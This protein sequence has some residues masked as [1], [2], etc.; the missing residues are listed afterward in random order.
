MSG[1]PILKNTKVLI[2]G[3]AGFIGSNLIETLLSQNNQIVCLDNFFTGKKENIIPFVNLPSFHFI[4]GDIRNINC[5]KQAVKGVTYVFHQA[6]IGS[7]PRSIKDPITTNSVNADGFLNMLIASRDEKVKR[8]I[9]ASSSSVYGDHPALPKKEESVGKP[10]SPYGITKSINEMYASVFAKLYNMEIIGLR[11]FNVFGKRQ[12]P[13]GE[14]AAAIPKFISLLI[15]KQSPEIF[16]DGNQSRD[17]TYIDNV[18][19]INQLAAL[20]T[21]PE[22]LNNVYNVAFGQKT[23]LNELIQIL[24]Q[25][26]SK[27]DPLIKNIIPVYSAERSGDIKHSVASIDKAK[28]LLGYDPKFSL[29]QGLEIA[30]DW[31]WK[32][33]SK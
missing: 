8:F 6:A 10:L 27:Y 20:S 9:Y 11:Y 3:G 30:I 23:D 32:T 5:C 18:I 4:E 24:C 33:L 22:S 28:N 16:G 12:D 25:L 13:N 7:V 21:L 19:Q 17:F 26:L 1:F 31:Y 29:Q 14:Y 15:Q 2:T